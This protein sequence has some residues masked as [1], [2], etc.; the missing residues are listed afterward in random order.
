MPFADTG[1][2]VADSPAI[3]RH[4]LEKVVRIGKKLNAGS[5][6]LRQAVPLACRFKQQWG[7]KTSPLLWHDV[8]LDGK[9]PHCETL[10]FRL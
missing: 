8:S 4:L 10:T 2:I 5:L 7:A 3:E 6:E 1:G 9:P